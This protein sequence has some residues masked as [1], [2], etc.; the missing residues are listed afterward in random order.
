MSDL[1]PPTF[2][3]A[4]DDVVDEDGAPITGFTLEDLTA[5]AAQ[6]DAGRT[7]ATSAAV[8]GARAGRAD[9]PL[10]PDRVARTEAARRRSPVVERLARAGANLEPDDEQPDPLAID[11]A[12]L[13]AIEQVA[14]AAEDAGGDPV[15]A[16]LDAVDSGNPTG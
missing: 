8:A 4:H 1:P 7:S 2:D 16:I 14:A 13:E 5:Q 10:D 12:E 15:D 11:D 3:R 9:T 6:R